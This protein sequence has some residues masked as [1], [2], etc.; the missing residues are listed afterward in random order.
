MMAGK[1]QSKPVAVIG[2][3]AAGLAAAFRL[4]QAG[5]KVLIIESAHA[6]GGKLRS[7]ERDGFV[8]DQGAFFLPSTYKHMVGMAMEAGFADQIDV[9]GSI[10]S[11]ARD[12]KLHDFDINHLVRDFLNT[13]LFSLGTKLSLGPVVKELWLSRKCNFDHMPEMGALDVEDADRWARRELSDELREYVAE[14]VLRGMAGSPSNQSPRVELPALFALFGGAKLLA[15]RGGFGEFANKL[16]TGIDVEL[17]ATAKEVTKLN[18]GVQ[19]IWTDRNGSEHVDM[20]AG[21]V[22]AGSTETVIDILPGLDAWR[23]QYLGNTRDKRSFIVNIGLSRPPADF[24]ETYAVLPQSAH[25]FIGGI[26]ADHNKAPGR[27]PAGKGLMSLMPVWD[28]CEPR[29]DDD[30]AG[31]LRDSIEGLES[32]VPGTA[33][34]VEFAEV[35]RWTQ[36]YNPIGHY[37]ELGR[38]RTQ[39]AQQDTTIQLAGDYFSYTNMETAICSGEQAAHNLIKA[40]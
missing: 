40:L 28:W 9:G 33:Q 14:L 32:I 12:G 20:F 23:R 4:K 18:D 5:L 38:F 22:V 27:V 11:V 29:F 7:K 30:D 10:I 35:S 15:C 25:A 6:V 2:S 13:D 31:I 8:I 3:G 19:V 36:R 24:V 17:H 37:R 39:C 26:C 34:N 16:A 21:C 1:L